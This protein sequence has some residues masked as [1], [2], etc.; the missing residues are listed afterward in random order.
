VYGEK[1]EHA[2]WP[3]LEESENEYEPPKIIE[4]VRDR[5]EKYGQEDS[6]VEVVN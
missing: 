4:E 6:K 2:F 3:T 1:G 5:S